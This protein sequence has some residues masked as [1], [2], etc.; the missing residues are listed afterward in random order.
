[1]DI[2]GICFTSREYSESHVIFMPELALHDLLCYSNTNLQLAASISCWW[3]SQTMCFSKLRPYFPITLASS[4]EK[5]GAAYHLP[6]PWCLLG[7]VSSLFPSLFPL[8][9]AVRR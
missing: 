6:T 4:C 7:R 9:P 8:A 3:D 5:D 2:H 1:M